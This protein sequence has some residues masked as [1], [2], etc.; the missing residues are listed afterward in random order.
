MF[1]R[2]KPENID[3]WH[4][5]RIM[6]QPLFLALLGTWAT[7]LFAFAINSYFFFIDDRVAQ[8]FAYGL[9]I[10]RSL[11]DGIFPFLTS[12]TIYGGALWLD[13][14]YGI[15]N[16]VALGL[17]F[18]IM[19]G[20]LGL[21]GL[22]HAL[23]VS[24]LLVCGT[25]YVGRSYGLRPP[26][27]A[28]LGLLMGINPYV[29][30]VASADWE[31]AAL[32]L[33]FFMF[34]W[35]SLKNL[36]DSSEYLSLQTLKTGTFIY[37][38]F[39]SGW[40]HTDAAFLILVFVL[41]IDGYRIGKPRTLRLFFLGGLAVAL[42]APALVPVF[43]AFAWTDRFAIITRPDYTL[44]PAPWDILNLSNP[45]W[46]PHMR[47]WVPRDTDPVPLFFLGWF[48]LPLLAFIR[49]E[50]WKWS[51]YIPLL[52]LLSI[53]AILAAGVPAIQ[54][55]RYPVRWLPQVHAFFLICLFLAMQNN[56][57]FKFGWG[58]LRF[59][60]ALAAALAMAAYWQHPIWEGRELL[61]LAPPLFTAAFAHPWSRRHCAL[62]LGITSVIAA[63]ATV[64][65]YPSLENT[66]NHWRKAT[67]TIIRPQQ[68]RNGYTLF[69]GWPRVYAGM[70]PARTNLSEEAEFP[71]AAI[72]IYYNNRTLNGYSSI[73]HKRAAK[74]FGCVQGYG[75]ICTVIPV[76]ALMR[77]EPETNE[78]YL[79]LLKIDT[80][81]TDKIDLRR[82]TEAALG[83][84]WLEKD[85]ATT[86]VFTRRQNHVLPGTVSWTS[87]SLHITGGE[88]R[89]NEESLEFVNSGGPGL[90]A[91]AR[92]YYP[93]FYAYLG[94][95]ELQVRPIDNL[96]VGVEVPAG[97]KGTLTLLFRPPYWFPS[98]LGAALGFILCGLG[99]ILEGKK[100]GQILNS[101]A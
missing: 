11:T 85:R 68:T 62:F 75:P 84:A 39:T 10:K 31:P 70:P 66:I 42:C 17:T 80:V 60:L 59:A 49:W 95:E 55:L 4:R 26:Y 52:A 91:F 25:Y 78:S 32:S 61:F 29:L 74:V 67:E 57:L 15:F 88:N 19:P 1:A 97:A 33:S 35:A 28:L 9:A 93:G 21:S 27:A 30:Y 99:V 41:L 51:D 6:T 34:A 45:S 7:L 71:S 36:L 63:I 87:P 72:G 20:H 54:Y 86:V 79:N 82:E 3:R 8:Y 92:L 77:H 13:W 89:E 83:D 90:I 12:R 69:S 24:S 5:A 47:L 96:L 44:T 100:S 50:K 94:N 16:P 101:A 22:L 58:R 81:V 37:L 65:T 38:M 40:P 53:F 76:A 48:T 64:Y 73:G 43:A 23:A 14:Q 56:D 46:W 2:N 98:L 18:L